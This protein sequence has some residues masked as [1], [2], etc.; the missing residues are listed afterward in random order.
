MKNTL[1][2]NNKTRP[3]NNQDAFNRV[4][5]RLITHANFG[6][7]ES[8]S[9]GCQYRRGD[10]NACAIGYMI[11][12]KMAKKLDITLN[13]SSLYAAGFIRTAIRDFKDVRDWF[14]NVDIDLL[15]KLQEIHDFS[16]INKDGSINKRDCIKYL[17]R[18]AK[19]YNLKM[20]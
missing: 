10:G 14:V 19:E 2:L 12:D 15:N 18:V 1:K 16:H 20:P 8:D 3:K 17:R 9:E 6:K 7:C 13:Y 11:S 5:E 4:Y